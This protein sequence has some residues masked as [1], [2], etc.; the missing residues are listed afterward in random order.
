[1]TRDNEQGRDLC[2]EAL[3][4]AHKSL[5]EGQASADSMKW[6]L[7]ILAHTYVSNPEFSRYRNDGSHGTPRGTKPSSAGDSPTEQ[8]ESALG[9]LPDESRLPVLLHDI[10]GLT[11]ADIARA[12]GIPVGS[13]RSRIFRGRR[14]LQKLLG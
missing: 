2:Y 11:Y 8:L 7:V 1:M 9:S 4:Q 5:D 13:V 10:E 14:Q 12:L 6:L 3:V